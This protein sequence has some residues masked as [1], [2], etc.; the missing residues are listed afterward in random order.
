M[1]PQFRYCKQVTWGSTGIVH[2]STLILTLTPTAILNPILILNH[3]PDPNRI[4]NPNRN[5][6]VVNYSGTPA[7]RY[8]VSYTPTEQFSE[9][10]LKAG[11]GWAEWSR[12]V[13]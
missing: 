1:A 5:P 12:N 13:W 7:T 8:N 2:H 9:H 4:P 6:R 3:D 10:D 11:C